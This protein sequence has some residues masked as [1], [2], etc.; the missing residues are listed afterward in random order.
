MFSIK[1]T[2]KSV[3]NYKNDN[4]CTIA[5]KFTKGQVPFQEDCFHRC[6]CP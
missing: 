3:Y 1:I 5:Y 2:S 4:K 6:L